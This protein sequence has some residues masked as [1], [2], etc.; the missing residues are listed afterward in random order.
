LAPLLPVEE[1]YVSQ[2]AHDQTERL[3]GIY[4]ASGC[5]EIGSTTPL[6]T[7]PWGFGMEWFVSEDCRYLVVLN[8]FG[9]GQQR[10]GNG[11]DWGLKFYDYGKEIRTQ[12]VSDLVDF[13]GLMPLESSDWH[14]RWFGDS[15]DSCTIENGEFVFETS[16]RESYRFELATGAIVHE[17]RVWRS[18]IRVASALVTAALFAGVVLVGCAVGKPRALVQSVAASR[19]KAEPHE[20]SFDHWLRYRIRT[21]FALTFVVAAACFATQRWPHVVVFLSPVLAALL[22]TR[23]TWRLHRRQVSANT[24]RRRSLVAFGIVLASLLWLGCYVLSAGPVGR[25]VHWL[26][27]PYDVR[28]AIGLTFYRP[29]FWASRFP[30]FNDCGPVRWYFAAWEGR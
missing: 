19:S 10:G 26:E 14:M 28:M 16:T 22:V 4:P 18:V 17:R 5:Y 20:H 1:G 27:A 3:N 21:L 2:E 29:L 30:E 24:T 12:H 6:W 15:P 11:P 25:M 8:I 7:A 23:A 13:P 9:D